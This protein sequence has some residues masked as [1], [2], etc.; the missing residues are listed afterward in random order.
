MI[1][2][3]PPELKESYRYAHRNVALV[4]W[5]AAFA[6]GFIGLLA[7]HACLKVQ[8]TR[9]RIKDLKPLALMTIAPLKVPA[10]QPL[11][12]TAWAGTR[13]PDATVRST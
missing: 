13:A 11:R 2:L 12:G 1:N 3:L 10:T 4:R 6:I 8:F 9:V 5:V 7:P